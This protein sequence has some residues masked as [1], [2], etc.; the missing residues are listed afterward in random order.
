MRLVVLLVR[1]CTVMLL[2]GV[3]GYASSQQ[4]MTPS[5]DRAAFMQQH[6]ALVTAVHD[7][8][9]HGDVQ[10]AR[11]Q[12][13]ALADRPDPQD[14]P[15]AAA[16]YVKDMK[17]AA[18][19]V[20]GAADLEDAAAATSSMLATCGDC[21]RAV[22]TMPARPLPSFPAVGGTVGHM[23]EHRAAV[24]LMVQ[25]LTVPST[26]LW[27][28]GAEGLRSAALRRG[29]LPRD[30]KLTKE[31]L[32]TEK[33]VHELAESARQASDTRAR[34]YVYSELIES[35]GTCHALHGNVWGPERK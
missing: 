15:A 17:R 29:E 8:V 34:I 19:R 11:K 18:A 4:S 30:P 14:L 9:I 28:Q 21:H 22:G 13:R 6:F 20:A 24:D 26:S 35:C 16:P 12:A 5:A 3:A 7:A 2:I 10:T 33:W 1:S 27:Q 23:L 25:G 31:I 32:A